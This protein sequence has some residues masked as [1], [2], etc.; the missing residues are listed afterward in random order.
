MQGLIMTFRILVAKDSQVPNS[1]DI[2]LDPIEIFAD[3]FVIV[4]FVIW[5]DDISEGIFPDFNG[6]ILKGESGKIEKGKPMTDGQVLIKKSM[7]LLDQ[8]HPWSQDVS[9]QLFSQ[10]ELLWEIDLIDGSERT[11]GSQS[12]SPISILCQSFFSLGQ[13]LLANLGIQISLSFLPSPTN[14]LLLIYFQI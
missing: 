12:I 5:Q 3:K 8:K 4:L 2:L 6:Y 13:F 14:E 7:V 10:N 11:L 1:A 9:Q